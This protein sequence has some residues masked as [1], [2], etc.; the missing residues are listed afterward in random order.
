MG[1]KILS[2]NRLLAIYAIRTRKRGNLFHL[3]SIN[4][5]FKQQKNSVMDTITSW[6][7]KFKKIYCNLVTYSFLLSYNRNISFLHTFFNYLFSEFSILENTNNNVEDLYNR[8][9]EPT[10]L[11][12]SPTTSIQLFGSLKYCNF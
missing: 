5:E 12:E 11:A 1:E 4:N 2:A 8:L 9:E 3:I 7:K 10:R 6:M